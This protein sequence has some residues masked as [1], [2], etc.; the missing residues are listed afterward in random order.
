MKEIIFNGDRLA[1]KALEDFIA[2]RDLYLYIN[3]QTAMTSY[4]QSMSL[5]SSVEPDEK[6]ANNLRNEV[7]ISIKNSLSH[8]ASQT[9][10]SF[11]T[12]YEIACKE[13]FKNL[14]IKHPQLMHDCVSDKYTNGTILLK[15][16]INAESYDEI[17]SNT[18]DK[19]ANSA[20]KG[21]YG[22]F[23]KRAAK[24]TR[25]DFNQDIVVQLNTLQLLRNRIIHEKHITPLTIDEL[26][27]AQSTVSASIEFLCRCAINKDVPGKYSCINPI[28]ISA[29]I[30]NISIL[31]D[32]L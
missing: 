8:F 15:E 4:T 30:E 26:S 32:T 17:V 10:V 23:I 22:D 9:I 3:N 5:H 20:S 7:E 19:A 11:C 14:F 28:Q 29:N 6:S 21:K 13:F 27:T 16:I 2:Y 25:L 31:I 1:W 24:S 12:T 18:A